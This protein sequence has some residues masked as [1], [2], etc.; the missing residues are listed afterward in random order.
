MYLKNEK[1]EKKKGTEEELEYYE[2]IEMLKSIQMNNEIE[3]NHTEQERVEGSRRR[4]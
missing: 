3:R 4:L 2:Y 1:L